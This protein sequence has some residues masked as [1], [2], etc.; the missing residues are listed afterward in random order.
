MESNVDQA[1]AIL[2][3]LSSVLTVLLPGCSELLGPP[4]SPNAEQSAATR[5]ENA[6]VVKVNAQI[7]SGWSA[8]LPLPL[9]IVGKASSGCPVNRELSGMAKSVTICR[10]CNQVDWVRNR[11]FRY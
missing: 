4:E 9:Q 8:T 10:Q 1:A 11:V 7:V 5:T 6:L 2:Q 3:L